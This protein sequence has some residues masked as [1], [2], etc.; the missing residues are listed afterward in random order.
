MQVSDAGEVTVQAV[1][2]PSA[3]RWPLL[4]A[5]PAASLSTK[6]ARAL[7]PDTYSRADAIANVQAVALLAGAFATGDG[8]L[9]RVAMADRMHQ[10]YRAPV[11]PLLPALLPL[12]GQHGI[13]GVALSGAGPSVLLILSEGAD[14]ESARAVVASVAEAHGQPAEVM[15][16]RIGSAAELGLS[17]R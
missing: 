14:V 5:M 10:P 4:V 11:C 12:A 2:V 6:T 13:L 15:S 16:T 8:D 1:V 17:A 9:L 7:L 3:A